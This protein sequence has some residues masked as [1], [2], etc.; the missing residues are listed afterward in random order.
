MLLC[1]D[2][3]NSHIFVGV[4]D[5]HKLVTTFRYNTSS[6]SSSDQIGVFFRGVLR[7][8]NID[9]HSIEAVAMCSVVPHLDYTVQSACQ[10]YFG[11]S[12]FII[13]PGVKTGLHIDYHNPLEVGADRIANAMGAVAQFPGRPLL[14][15]DLGTATTFCAVS[16]DKHYLGGVIQVGMRLAMDALQ[17]NTAKLPAVEIAKPREVLGRS[18]KHSLQSGVYYS[19]L[20]MIRAMV[21]Q[22]SA[23]VFTD[24]PPC[25]IG[26]G[27]F[28]RGFSEEGVFDVIVSDLVLY[29]LREAYA[30][31]RHRIKERVS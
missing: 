3:G 11:I 10:K 31:N 15:V 12:P 22:I 7:E 26:T 1:L 9:I 2:V 13:Q 17:G 30:M 25:V 21:L 20:A 28:A 18:T 24:E 23:E 5:Q 27:G 29:G 14:L 6:A 8:K 4:F 16:A 19:Q